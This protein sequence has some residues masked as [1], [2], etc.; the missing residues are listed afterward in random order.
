MKREDIDLHSVRPEHYAIHERLE[1]WRRY[2]APSRG[3]R[4]M[5]PM[6]LN[7][8]PERDNGHAVELRIPV[9]TQDGH[10]IEVAVGLLPEKHS[11][12]IRWC[13]VWCAGSD[14]YKPVPI[15]RVRQ[16]LAVTRSG[17]ADLIHD[18]RAMLKN[19]SSM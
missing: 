17:L 19:R 4:G 10:A 1:N 5:A 12:A 14:K 13:Y 18:G 3:G 6:W 7:Y 9:N 2:V 11:I 8:K 15:H 16:F